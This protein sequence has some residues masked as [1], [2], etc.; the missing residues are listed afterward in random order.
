MRRNEIGK[1]WDPWLCFAAILL[2]GTFGWFAVQ[3]ADAVA[4]WER[5]EQHEHHDYP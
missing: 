1:G 4:E 3:V 2:V 5:I